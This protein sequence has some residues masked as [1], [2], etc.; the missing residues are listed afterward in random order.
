MD[1]NVPFKSENYL[2]AES[3]FYDQFNECDFYIEDEEQEELY[4]LIIK[5]LFPKI[6]MSK[7]F[8]LKGK[9]NVLAH[10]FE[11]NGTKKYV[12]IL[13]KDFDDL[14]NK[15]TD[16]DNI[17]YLKCYCIENYLLE[18]EAIVSFVISEKPKLKR[19]DIKKRFDSKLYIKYLSENFAYLFFL[20]FLVQSRLSRKIKNCKKSP[21]EF[22]DKKNRSLVNAAAIKT[23]EKELSIVLKNE[24][25]SLSIKE[26]Y[27]KNESLFAKIYED[28]ILENISGK[29]LLNF[30]Q[31]KIKIE[32][33][34]SQQPFDS[35]RYR[36]AQ[37]CEFTQLGY[38][39]KNIN[40]YLLK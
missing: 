6:S 18:N 1:E 23:F 37:Q 28:N 27:L 36:I 7:I 30:M 39:K 35:F 2:Y 16:R 32:F 19:S 17:F 25:I 4:Y 14:L 11:N 5:K 20:Y 38:L 24:N 12:Y 8:P 21:E 9:D 10:S 34:C 33:K 26:E 3:I 15:T 22:R 31:K 13:D 29:Y 40:N